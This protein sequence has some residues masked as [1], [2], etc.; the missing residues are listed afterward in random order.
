MIMH[1]GFPELKQVIGL[2]TL[3]GQRQFLQ[4]SIAFIAL[5]RDRV[6]QRA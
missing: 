4:M 3:S 5:T 1:G 2:A 6:S